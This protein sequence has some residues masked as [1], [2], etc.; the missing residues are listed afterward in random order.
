MKIKILYGKRNCE[1]MFRDRKLPTKQEIE[2]QW[3]ELPSWVVFNLE[4][5]GLCLV[6]SQDNQPKFT[7]EDI[8]RRMNSYA[9][10]PLAEEYRNWDGKGRINCYDEFDNAIPLEPDNPRFGQNWM[11]EN[12]VGHTSMSIGDIVVIEGYGEIYDGY[13]YTMNFGFDKLSFDE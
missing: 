11:S 12:E 4:E 5:D 1:F 6:P 8:F 10:N 2:E 3:A 7:L 13:Y 9:T